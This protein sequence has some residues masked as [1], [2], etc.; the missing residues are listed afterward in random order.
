MKSLVACALGFLVALVN[1]SPAKLGLQFDKRDDLP[2]L[3][4]PYATYRAASYDPDGDVR[5]QSSSIYQTWLTLE[6]C[7]TTL[8]RTFA[9]ERRLSAI[10]DGPSLHHHQPKL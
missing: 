8:S 6:T 9:L 3:K 2:L 10:F 4:L 1:A 7:S 5:P